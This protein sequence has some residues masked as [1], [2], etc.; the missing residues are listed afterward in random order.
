[1]GSRGW[2]DNDLVPAGQRGRCRPVA[3]DGPLVD[4]ERR[5]LADLFSASLTAQCAWPTG[6][7][8]AAS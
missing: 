3:I 8:Y 2:F 6:E 5:R 7:R 4:A 1:M